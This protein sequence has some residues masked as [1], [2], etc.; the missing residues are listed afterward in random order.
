MLWK[1][2]LDKKQRCKALFVKGKTTKTE[3]SV[4]VSNQNMGFQVFHVYA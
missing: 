1:Y 4:K 2:Y 3:Y